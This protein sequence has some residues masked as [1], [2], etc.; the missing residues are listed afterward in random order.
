MRVQE[1][2]AVS[3][4]VV[5]VQASWGAALAEPAAFLPAARRA[6]EGDLGRVRAE[7]ARRGWLGGSLP[8][9]AA[10]PPASRRGRPAQAAGRRP[11]HKHVCSAT[12]SPWAF[13]GAHFPAGPVVREQGPGSSLCGTSVSDIFLLIMQLE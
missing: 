3:L 6:L 10:R 13:S 4:A 1:R 5:L 9:G 7:A 11:A 12:R 8:S 2:A